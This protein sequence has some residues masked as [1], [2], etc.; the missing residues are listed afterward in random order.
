MKKESTLLARSGLFEFLFIKFIL[1]GSITLE[2][3]LSHTTILPKLYL[4]DKWKNN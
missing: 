1:F 2:I 4:Y 3:K